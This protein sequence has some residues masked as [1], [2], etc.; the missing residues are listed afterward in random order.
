MVRLLSL[1]TSAVSVLAVPFPIIETRAAPNAS[2]VYVSGY[3]YSGSGCPAGT[4][5]YTLSDDR[6]VSVKLK[7]LSSRLANIFSG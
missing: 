6:S 4:S 1:L 3:S 2:L 7:Y 5:G